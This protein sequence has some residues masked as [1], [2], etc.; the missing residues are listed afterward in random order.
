MPVLVTTSSI[1]IGRE[2][3][4]WAGSRRPGLIGHLPRTG[5]AGT[6]QRV[7]PAAWAASENT[8]LLVSRTVRSS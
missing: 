6:D 4:V 3:P 7:R 5:D 2:T 8:G 1:V